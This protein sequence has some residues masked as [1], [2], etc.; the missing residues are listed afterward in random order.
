MYGAATMLALAVDDGSPSY[1][2]Y[3]QRTSTAIS[4]EGRLDTTYAQSTALSLPNEVQRAVTSLEIEKRH[5]SPEEGKKRAPAAGFSLGS[6]PSPP[7]RRNTVERRRGS[8]QAVT[9]A[10]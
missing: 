1:V 10:A 8:G 7:P 2:S 6:G 3:G 4:G 5:G 9:V